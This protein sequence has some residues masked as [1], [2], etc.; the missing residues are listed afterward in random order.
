M[1][2]IVQRFKEKN[3]HRAILMQDGIV[4][5][6]GEADLSLP[7]EELIDCVLEHGKYDISD[8]QTIIEENH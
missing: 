2:I 4:L 6:I 7:Q 8:V 5:D 3:R 1:N